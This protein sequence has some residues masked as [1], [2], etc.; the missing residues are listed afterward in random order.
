MALFFIYSKVTR[1]LYY[2]IISTYMHMHV[3]SRAS[4]INLG[5]STCSTYMYGTLPEMPEK[6]NK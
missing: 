5:E 6:M 2:F 4:Y 1:Y 3:Y